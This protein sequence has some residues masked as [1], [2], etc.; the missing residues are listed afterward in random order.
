MSRLFWTGVK[1][2]YAGEGREE[3]AAFV[4][5]KSAF[6]KAPVSEKMKESVFHSVCSI[7]VHEWLSAFP[8]IKHKPHTGEFKRK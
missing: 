6:K 8:L 5:V 1:P 2:I 7:D 3:E 4:G